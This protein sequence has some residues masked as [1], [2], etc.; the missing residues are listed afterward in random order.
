M[1]TINELRTLLRD[2]RGWEAYFRSINDLLGHVAGFNNLVRDIK[3]EVSGSTLGDLL[4]RPD[5][6]PKK[7]VL[8]GFNTDRKSY[9]PRSLGLFYRMFLGVYVAKEGLETFVTRLKEGDTPIDAGRD[10]PV[11]IEESPITR[12]LQDLEGQLRHALNTLELEPEEKAYEPR[13]PLVAL[14]ALA[15]VLNKSRTIL[16]LYNKH[17]FILQ[18]LNSTPTFYLERTGL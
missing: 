14:K 8:G 7:M 13:D 4:A 5:D 11:K 9:E 6:L 2:R 3:R 1:S 16:P 12:L 15:K 18:S 10:I 17:S